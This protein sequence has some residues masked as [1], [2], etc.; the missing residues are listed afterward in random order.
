MSTATQEYTRV[1]I[2]TGASRG[3]GKGIALRLAADGLDVVV[4]DLA[5]QKDPL[6]AVAEEIR[7]LGRKVLT[8]SC[9]VSKEDE[10]QALVDAAVSELGRLDVMVANAGVGHGGS[11][12]DAEIEAW[13]KC[14]AVNIKGVLFCYKHAARQMVKQGAGGRIIGA[15]SIGGQ[16]GYAGI[17]AYCISKAAVR[18]LTQTTALELREYNITVNAYA[19]GIIDTALG[20]STASG[21]T[22]SHKFS[23][24]H[25]LDEG[26]GAGY[27]VKQLFKIP[28][29]VRTGQPSDVANVVSFLVSPQSHF[30]TGQTLCVD[31]GVHFT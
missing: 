15:S 7:G 29:G 14:W 28:E 13:E 1:A 11:V 2:V 10:V 27:F 12:M 4:A 30:V 20:A 8:V 6:D 25:P 21:L 16:R 3:I 9:D 23:A 24:A 22:S 18:S 26:H 19:P 5:D 17:G 31:D